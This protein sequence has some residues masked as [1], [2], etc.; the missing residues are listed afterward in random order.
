MS[1][2]TWLPHVFRRQRARHGGRRD[3][4]AAV[5]KAFVEALAQLRVEARAARHAPINAEAEK[6]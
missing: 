3:D 2:N 5:F 6:N 1:Q 4:P